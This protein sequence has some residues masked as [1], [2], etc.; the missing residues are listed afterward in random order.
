MFFSF[1]KN[2]QSGVLGK[3]LEI[4]KI[5]NIYLFRVML[6]NFNFFKYWPYSG[7]V[8]WTINVSEML[9]FVY[10]ESKSVYARP[11]FSFSQKK[12]LV[13]LWTGLK[14]AKIPNFQFVSYVGSCCIVCIVYTPIPFFIFQVSWSFND[15][16]FVNFQSIAVYSQIY[17]HFF[18]SN[19]SIS[20]IYL[21][22]IHNNK[23][24]TSL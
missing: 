5:V 6:P 21:W 19:L 23:I 24:E 14:I 13:S 9:F 1:F 4:A 18:K 12:F 17:W 22:K 2:N 11:L 7:R 10:M 15:A 20:N 16:V 8:I 3:S